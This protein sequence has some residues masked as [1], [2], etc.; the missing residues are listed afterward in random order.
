MNTLLETTKPQTPHI[1]RQPPRPTLVDASRGAR[2]LRISDP[3]HLDA[4]IIED[5]KESDPMLGHNV[6]GTILRV[7]GQ[8]IMAAP[9]GGGDELLTVGLRRRDDD[10]EIELQLSLARK[11][12]A[13]QSCLVLTRVGERE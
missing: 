11:R 5:Y 6:A 1:N 2:L 8:H 7:L 4:S 10:Q 13:G 12:R 3:V 9:G